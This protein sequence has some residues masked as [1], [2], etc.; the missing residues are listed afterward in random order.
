MSAAEWAYLLVGGFAFYWLAARLERL[1]S[2]IEAACSE[3]QVEMAKLLGNEERAIELLDEWKQAR[4]EAKK[5]QRQGAWIVAEGLALVA[6]G[7]AL[8]SALT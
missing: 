7:L 1:G 8:V 2:Q 4:A 6:G 3:L 5:E